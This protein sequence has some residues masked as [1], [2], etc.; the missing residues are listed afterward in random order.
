MSFKD[1]IMDALEELE[2]MGPALLLRA[3]GC[4]GVRHDPCA[5]PVSRFLFKRT[6]YAETWGVGYTAAFLHNEL[7]DTHTEI[8]LLPPKVQAFVF[9]FD[10]GQHPEL[11]Q[12]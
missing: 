2:V 3:A 12:L 7:P 1:T 8:V 9:E 10:G 11:L 5:C 4:R 6:G